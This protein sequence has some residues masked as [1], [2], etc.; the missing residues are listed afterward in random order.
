MSAKNRAI[1][2]PASPTGYVRP[3]DGWEPA[4]VTADVQA[5]IDAAVRG[6]IA[7]VAAGLRLTERRAAL[8]VLGELGGDAIDVAAIDACR[9]VNEELVGAL[10]QSQALVRALT[11]QLAL[12]IQWGGEALVGWDME[13]SEHERTQRDWESLDNERLHREEQIEKAHARTGCEREWTSAHDLGDCLAQSM[14]DTQVRIEQAEKAK[15]KA[16]T[17]LAAEAHARRTA[18]ALVE[19]MKT[20]GCARLAWSQSESAQRTAEQARDEATGAR[21][22]LDNALQ[23]LRSF[24]AIERSSAHGIGAVERQRDA[25]RDEISEA[26]ERLG[27]LMGAASIHGT[28]LADH[29]ESVRKLLAPKAGDVLVT[30]D[31]RVVARMV[32]AD[33][34]RVDDGDPA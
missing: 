21:A 18:E 26:K 12:A 30:T 31:E 9:R 28:A 23:Q 32:G 8:L 13:R 14:R 7:V 5:Q 2:D 1:D 22:A 27:A 16:L 15:A 6:R 25:L 10:N 3:P 11:S 29:V 24:H 33:R 20:I 34:A 17:E 4:H 19:E